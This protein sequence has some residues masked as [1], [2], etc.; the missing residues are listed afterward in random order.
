MIDGAWGSTRGRSIHCMWAVSTSCQ[1]EKAKIYA[2]LSFHLSIAPDIGT[3][4]A[5]HC[6]KFRVKV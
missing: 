6:Q 1:G 5:K 2:V 3:D 4:I